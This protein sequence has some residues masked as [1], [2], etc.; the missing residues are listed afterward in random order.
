MDT[1]LFTCNS[2]RYYCNT[3]FPTINHRLNIHITLTRELTTMLTGHGSIKACY[4]RLKII[5]DP[6]STCGGGSQTAHF[7]LYDCELRNRENTQP[8]DIV[9]TNGDR[10]PINKNQLVTKYFIKFKKQS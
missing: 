10:W 8:K 6:T 4:H 1:E 7:L 2:N 3:T 5:K 9:I